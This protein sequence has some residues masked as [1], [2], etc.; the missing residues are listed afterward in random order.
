MSGMTLAL[1][2]KN[3]SEKRSQ[4]LFKMKIRASQGSQHP[5]K[6]TVLV[7]RLLGDARLSIC[8]KR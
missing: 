8:R 2:K 4:T 3:R 5:E 7:V 6:L 1:L